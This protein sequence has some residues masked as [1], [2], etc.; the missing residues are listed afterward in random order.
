MTEFRPRW[1]RLAAATALPVLCTALALDAGGYASARVPANPGAAAS[2][3]VTS[4]PRRAVT[5][6]GTVRSVVY[7]GNRV[8]VGGDFTRARNRG[9]TIVR[10]HVAALSARTGRLLRWNPRPSGPVLAI[11]V[12]RKRVYL[13][14]D[15]SRVRGVRRRNLA[16]VTV[17]GR[18]VRRFRHAPNRQVSA[19]AISGHTLYIGGTFGAVGGRDRDR[20]AAINLRNNRIRA[21]WRPSVS[22]QV[23]ALATGR[24]RV[25]VGGSFSR[26]NGRRGTKFLSAVGTARGHLDSSFHPS[27]DYRVLDLAVTNGGVFAAADG[28][29][30]NLRAFRLNGRDRWDLRTNGGVQAVTVLNHRVYFGGHFGS[31]CRVA[32]RHRSR[33]RTRQRTRHKLAAATAHGRL[34]RWNPDA[35]SSLGVVAMDSAIRPARVAA[36]GAFTRVGGSPRRFFARFG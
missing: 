17:S 18:V 5:F 29:G 6:N 13:G 24:R 20:L 21:R 12:R 34:V 22:G 1:A 7:A 14:G 30:G 3:T 32:S 26:V 15:F 28:P 36:G 16:K 10:H 4:T 23:R 9:R 31:V 27:I 8:Y 2:P 25:Y 33:C 19:M 35:N 11:A